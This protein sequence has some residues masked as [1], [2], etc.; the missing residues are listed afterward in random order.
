MIEDPVAQWRELSALYEQ[1]DQLSG[2]ALRDWIAGLPAEARPFVPRLERMLA[3]RD[4]AAADQFLEVPPPLADEIEHEPFAWE[5]GRR[6]GAYRLVRH[7]GSG[8]MAEVW[9][10]ER[11]DGAFARTV[12]I[13]LLRNHPTRA[14]RDNFVERFKRERDILASLDHPNIAGLLDAGVS[15]EGQPWLAL[16]FVEGEA[17]TTW[18][19]R[20][21]LTIEDRVRL[22]RQVMLAIEHA[23]ARLV[24]HRD[25]KPSNVLVTATGAVSLLDFGIA[26]L[27]ESDG[28]SHIA[29]ALTRQGGRPMTPQ[30]ASPEQ[31]LGEPLTTACDV[32]S[33]GVMLYELL[34]GQLP[35]ELKGRS[36]AE[37]EAAVT[38]VEPVPP[39]Y[40]RM[41]AE[42]LASRQT[43]LN[44]W[45]R[46]L[47]PDL[48]AITMRSLEK[49]PSL[50]Y[51]SVGAMRAELD[52]WL[53]H[54]PVLATTPGPA[55]R[56]AKFVRRHRW[57][58]TLA[59]GAAA[60]MLI[61]TS[62]VAWQMLRAEQESARA[63]AS[64][65]FLLDMF[66]LSDPNLAKVDDV[67]AG[68]LLDVSVVRAQSLLEQQPELHAD[69][70]LRIAEIDQYLNRYKAAQ[71]A[72][73]EATRIYESLGR[74][75]EWVSAMVELLH[76]TTRIGDL[77]TSDQLVDTMKPTLDR[78][79]DDFS[80]QA[81]QHEARGWLANARG[82]LSGAM[83]HMLA[84]VSNARLAY[85]GPD[86]RTA[87]ALRGLA[88]VEAS[89]RDYGAA[90]QH[91]TEAKDVANSARNASQTDKISAEIDLARIEF[92]AG[93]FRQALPLMNGVIQRCDLALGARNESCTT[94]RTQ[95]VLLL[96][97][98]DSGPESLPDLQAFR[99]QA[100]ND[101][102]P[103]YQLGAK[104]MMLRIFAANS[105]WSDADAV[106]LQLKRLIGGEA[107]KGF[108]DESIA[109]AY[110]ALEE[111]EIREG[112]G[113]A[114]IKTMDAIDHRVNLDEIEP[115]YKARA[116]ML[117]G[118]AQQAI[119]K[120][121]DALLTLKAAGEAYARSYGPDHT[122]TLLCR[123]NSLVSVAYQ[124]RWEDAI[125]LIDATMPTLR[126]RLPLGAPI[127]HRV[128][129]VRSQMSK[130]NGSF[131]MTLPVFFN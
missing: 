9:L 50:R 45:R 51:E 68:Q 125:S 55:Y 37:L 81:R 11:D 83:T 52:R 107:N 31:L 106:G 21:R 25:V 113:L 59:G 116:L 64:K 56:L 39:R 2:S 7:A 97:K 88:M 26:K 120:H 104:I 70:L 18:C 103:Q 77:K 127:V 3:A 123:L 130:R 10:A 110:F 87:E 46:A 95:R 65:A 108:P 5:A 86:S 84:A 67:S 6:I 101:L 128:E 126:D 61:A 47:K 54:E 72:L 115:V 23:H 121:A 42:A 122:Q 99:S 105:L 20:E 76:T 30:Y 129:V 92:A 102:S 44:G 79:P 63:L 124:G 117:R 100:E 74:R 96:I 24:I 29:T 89:S 38:D 13:K 80:I 22:F 91:A 94:M 27:L 1:A 40:R 17:I 66:H 53:A 69:V 75:K 118:L 78:F 34:V 58:V 73:I 16:E 85:R 4:R 93:E 19:D 36:L 8:G 131:P 109:A 32:Y 112:H 60:A 71:G 14:E 35:Y 98:I 111:L 15:P 49:S 90:R 33:L 28:D 48:D 41:S 43:S 62:I 119:G 57:G 82:D 12:A 114:A